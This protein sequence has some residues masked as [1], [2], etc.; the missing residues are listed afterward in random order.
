MDDFKYLKTDLEKEFQSGKTDTF[1]DIKKENEKEKQVLA[2]KLKT[3]ID[4]T[5][6]NI[7]NN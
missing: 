6:N 7:I 4:T 5:I 3:D 1:S 2:D